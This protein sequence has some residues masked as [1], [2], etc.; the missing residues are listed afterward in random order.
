MLNPVLVD[1]IQ[2]GI[3][4]FGQFKVEGNT[5]PFRFSAGYLP[6]YP[7]LLQKLAEAAAKQITPLQLDRLVTPIEA[8]PF[9]LACSLHTGISLAYA[10]T[11]GAFPVQNLVGA[12]DSGHKAAL[13]LNEFDSR[14]SLSQFITHA[15]RVGLEIT[16]VVAIL[17]INEGNAA[18]IPVIPLFRLDEL[19]RSLTDE[20]QV[21]VEQAGVV[22]LWAAEP[23]ISER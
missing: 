15:H 5:I 14:H 13:L 9:S 19:L 20:G 3:L 21:S 6:A 18:G 16:A 4:E 12:Y 17:S 22:R 2:S 8:L 11:G 1:M 23:H 7:N 10:A